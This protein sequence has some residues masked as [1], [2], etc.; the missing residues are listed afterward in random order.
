[1]LVV[2]SKFRLDDLG[3]LSQ[4]K[5]MKLAIDLRFYQPE[6][7]GL[8]IHIRDLFTELVPLLL[9]NDQFSQVV[10]IFDKKLE[11]QD[12]SQFL[13]WWE[14]VQ[15]Y[16]KFQIY[17][18]RAKYYSLEEQTGFLLDLNQLKCDLVYFFTFNYPI[19]YR[20]PFVYQVLDLSIPK[21]RPRWN[22]RVQA[23]LLCLRA[24][25]A[26][27]KHIIFLGKNTLADAERFSKYQFSQPNQVNY[28]PNSVV[29]NGLNPR[30]LT[31]TSA[32]FSKA[33]LT[34]LPFDPEQALKL[35]TL[36]SSKKI[37]KPYFLFVSVWRKYKNIERLVEAFAK[38][39]A[40]YKNAYQLVLGGRFD[41]KYPEI[42][43]FV[44]T[45]PQFTSGNIIVLGEISDDSELILLQDGAFGFVAP[46]LSEGFG[47]WMVEATS[48]GTPV[49]C[50]DIPIFHEILQDDGACFF[51]P[52]EVS[53][54]AKT[55]E[56]FVQTDS[57]QIEA[58]VKRAITYTKPFRWSN[59]AKQINHI[60]TE[61]LHDQKT[62]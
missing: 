45:H 18:S 35:N 25:L 46:S 9:D 54:I 59:I 48:R 2:F 44:T 39:Q 24:G 41:P 28:R 50:S 60:L 56:F 3:S 10:L 61:A 13:S 33:Q 14:I 16:P 62:K 20:R 29:Y 23:M 8:A 17:F 19:L 12:L 51:D 6:P 58:M 52:K 15:H 53:S 34:G 27:A 31:Q 1:M 26:N 7:Y 36:L 37:S 57:N 4:F 43:K 55:L 11:R 22:L 47:L 32:D 38:F 40:K 5:P 42:Q 21:T 49:V 30:Y